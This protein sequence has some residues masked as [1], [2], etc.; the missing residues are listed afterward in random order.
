[1]V[2]EWIWMVLGWPVVFLGSSFIKDHPLEVYRPLVSVPR[3]G[4]QLG[5]LGPSP[6]HPGATFGRVLRWFWGGFTVVWGGFR[7]VL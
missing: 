6:G 3:R 4:L 7:V 5:T 2:A 1:M